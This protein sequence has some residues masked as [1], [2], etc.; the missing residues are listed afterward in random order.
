MTAKRL[1]PHARTKIKRLER[2]M[3]VAYDDGAGVWTIGWGH[4]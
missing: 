3:L 2:L 4:T 1:S